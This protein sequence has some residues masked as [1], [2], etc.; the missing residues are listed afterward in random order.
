M[1]KYENK[2]V[3]QPSNR[4]GRSKFTAVGKLRSC[5]FPAIVL[6]SMT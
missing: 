2:N 5:V 1:R 6:I 3:I 4:E